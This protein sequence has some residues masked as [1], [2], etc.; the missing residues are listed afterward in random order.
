M[1]ER[2]KVLLSS[3]GINKAIKNEVSRIMSVYKNPRD[4]DERVIGHLIYRIIDDDNTVE[5]ETSNLDEF[6][7]KNYV[8]EKQICHNN[9]IAKKLIQQGKLQHGDFIIC[10]LN[11]VLHNFFDDKSI[12]LVMRIKTELDNKGKQKNI[13]YSFYLLNLTDETLETI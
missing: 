8:S 12:F 6:F 1:V 5:Y 11:H 7:R 2:Q 13:G 9:D 4:C 3:L 10:F